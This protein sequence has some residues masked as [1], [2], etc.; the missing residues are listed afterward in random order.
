MGKPYINEGWNSVELLDFQSN[1]YLYEVQ[2]QLEDYDI[3]VQINVEQIESFVNDTVDVDLKQVEDVEITRGFVRIKRDGKGRYYNI[4]NIRFHLVDFIDGI[5][6]LGIESDYKVI[7]GILFLTKMMG[8]LGVDLPE[9]YIAVCLALYNA[10]KCYCIT[11][12]NVIEIITREL[13]KSNYGEIKEEEV[14]EI[15]SGLIDLDIVIIDNGRFR[16]AQKIYS[17]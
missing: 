11:D 7:V 13:E 6:N 1:K 12:E 16:V 5:F 4:K 15:I 17:L 9:E 10:S 8:Y 14:D 3:S 2:E